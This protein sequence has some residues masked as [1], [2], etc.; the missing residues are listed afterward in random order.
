M[1]LINGAD[2]ASETHCAAVIAARYAAGRSLTGTRRINS[3]M[4]R[5]T[6]VVGSGPRSRITTRAGG[7]R[8]GRPQLLP[9]WMAAGGWSKVRPQPAGQGKRPM[10]CASRGA[11]P[12]PADTDAAAAEGSAPGRPKG[13]CRRA[14][15]AAE[16]QRVA[17]HRGGSTDAALRAA[18]RRPGAARGVAICAGLLSFGWHSG[19]QGWRYK[20]TGPSRPLGHPSAGPTATRRLR[21]L[22]IFRNSLGLG[23]SSIG[24]DN[25]DAK[26]TLAKGCPA[27]RVHR[28]TMSPEEIDD[29]MEALHRR[30]RTAAAPSSWAP[31]CC[32][33]RCSP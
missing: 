18:R 20:P 16:T 32:P 4:R 9:C 12:G 22:C 28:R 8:A 15:A 27:T 5:V 29:E 30:A 26:N 6:C 2:A 7:A 13:R 31:L 19:L 23:A 21:R 17:A 1:Q 14:P 10:Y 3:K 25:A 24:R 11:A 33:L